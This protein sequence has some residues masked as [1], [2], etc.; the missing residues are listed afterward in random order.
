MCDAESCQN[1][2]TEHTVTHHASWNVEGGKDRKGG[3]C[4]G[5]KRNQIPDSG[6]GIRIRFGL[7]LDFFSDFHLFFGFSGYRSKVHLV[8]ES[9]S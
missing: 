3:G 9:G 8:Q 5:V 7:I 2:V 6:F 1:W 4:V